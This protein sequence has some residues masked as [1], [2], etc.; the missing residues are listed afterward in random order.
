MRFI[1]TALLA[2][3][4]FCAATGPAKAGPVFSAQERAEGLRQGLGMGLAL[5]AEDNGYPGPRHV[6]DLADQLQLTPDQRRRTEALLAQMTAEATPA[7]ERL[8][9]DE[10]AVD[11]LFI[12]RAA[13]PERIRAAL[14]ASAASGSALQFVHLRYHLLM[15]GLLSPEQIRRYAELRAPPRVRPESEARST[16]AVAAGHGH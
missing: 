5:P 10:A 3:A 14:E 7:A 13:S 8:L 2:G 1:L 16:A 6:L 15:T 11:R 12:D 9:A 4:V